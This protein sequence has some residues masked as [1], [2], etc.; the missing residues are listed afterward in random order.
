[1][2]L[3]TFRQLSRLPPKFDNTIKA[4]LGLLTNN[5]GYNP[6]PEDKCFNWEAF[7]RSIDRDQSNKIVFDAYSSNSESSKMMSVENAANT[8]ANFILGSFR[9][10]MGLEDIQGNILEALVNLER[11]KREDWASFVPDHSAASLG[12]AIDPRPASGLGQFITSILSRAAP[13][14]LRREARVP[15]PESFWELRF[16]LC[17]NEPTVPDDFSAV[18]STIKI[19]SVTKG[20]VDWLA[21]TQQTSRNFSL[22]LTRMNVVVTNGFNRDP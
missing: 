22:E 20:E 2:V 4:F 14:G 10:L 7:K 18:V 19:G 15:D 8:A 3:S 21:F 17:S 13:S 6:D 5:L 11:G 12:R 1:M 16:L 9:P